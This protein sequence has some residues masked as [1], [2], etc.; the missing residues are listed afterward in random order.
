MQ[1]RQLLCVLALAAWAVQPPAT[2]AAADLTAREVTAML[3][4]ASP[5][6]PVDLQGKD[7]SKLDL[8]GLDFSNADLNG[9]NFYGA[10][11]TGAKFVG[12][13]MRKARLDRATLIGANFT[14][15]DL[16]GATLL[17]PNNFSEMS[18]AVAR[19]APLF[20]NAKLISANLNGRFDAVD[21]HGADLTDAFLG[22]RDPREE[23]LITPMMELRG[24]DFTG[25][26][27]R[28]A[29]LALNA[30]ELAKFVGADLTSANLRGARLGGADFTRAQLAG[31]NFTGA[32]LQSTVFR[33]TLGIE[34]A[35][36]LTSETAGPPGDLTAGRASNR[37]NPGAI[38]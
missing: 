2:A 28:G 26:T 21:F 9:T 14:D 29:E 32:T 17:R 13:K 22:P 6:R 16:T 25:A 33:D 7:L 4:K 18:D 35:V 38:R 24:A 36:G 34:R 8:A 27:M 11:L 19:E 20:A 10:D 31:A 23:V 37:P 30:L 12:A 3:F 1:P 5:D 15:A